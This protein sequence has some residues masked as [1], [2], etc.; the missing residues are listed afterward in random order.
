MSFVEVID[1]HESPRVVP[2]SVESDKEHVLLTKVKSLVSFENEKNQNNEG[3]S[4]ISDKS[5]V[6]DSKGSSESI[7]ISDKSNVDLTSMV[8]L[9]SFQSLET[10]SD[11][12]RKRVFSIFS[13]KRRRLSFRPTK[14]KAKSFTSGPLRV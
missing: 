11:S 12:D 14:T 4:N 7:T 9:D 1:S 10:Q 5:A 3:G 2:S 8:E 13:W 6:F